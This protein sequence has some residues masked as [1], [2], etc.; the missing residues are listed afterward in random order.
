MRR[1]ERL[2]RLKLALAA[3]EADALL[4]LSPENRRYLSGFPPLDVS[5]T[6]SAGAL[7][8]TRTSQFL[9]TD[10][11]YREEARECAPL[12]EP[13]IYEQ[14]LFRKLAEIL[15]VL[16]V[17]K[18]LFEETHLS[19]AGFKALKKALKG[20]ELLG[21]SG[22]VERVREVKDEGEIA[23]LRQALEI[24]ENILS[25]VSQMIRPGMSERELAA[26]IISL[27]YRWAEGP[28]F[29]PIVAVGPNAARPHAEPTETKFQPGQPLIIDLGV[30][31]QGYC[32]DITRT[33]CVGEPT[34]RFREVYTLVLEAKRKAEEKIAAGVP[35]RVP[36]LAARE[37]FRKAG[38]EDR[39]WHS[40]GHGVGLAIHEAPALSRRQ[41]RKLK[42]GHVVTVE[43]GLYFPDWGGVRL[44]DMVVVKERGL[45]R[46]NRLGFLFEA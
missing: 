18:L 14:G 12:F 10:P 32:S 2:R 45:E 21:V 33:F 24:A 30:R 1:A 20:V 22:L 17:K 44:E 28:S 7:L 25:R 6:E 46:L 41:R 34:A 23:L 31:Y 26:E 4:V 9:L 15:P 3:R 43:P 36:D 42:A 16:R 8:I 38:L 40:L 39:F 29:P 19:L 37:V 11:R 27:S 5:L 13:L 35:A